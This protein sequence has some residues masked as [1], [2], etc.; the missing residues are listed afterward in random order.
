MENV[1]SFKLQ[2]V[3]GFFLAGVRATIA[4]HT[5]G[6]PCSLLS[7]SETLADLLS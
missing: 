3:D 1:L 2:I 4:L 6:L 5:L 7:S